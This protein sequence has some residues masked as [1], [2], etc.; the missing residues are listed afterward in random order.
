MKELFNNATKSQIITF[1]SENF[2]TSKGE[3]L[4]KSQLDNFKKDELAQV[5][6]NADVENV[7]EDF[8]TNLT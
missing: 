1:I 2:V 6:I 3:C 5:I 4:T 7:F 8:L